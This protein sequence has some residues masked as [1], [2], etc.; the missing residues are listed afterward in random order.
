MS[1][2]MS[3]KCFWNIGYNWTKHRAMHDEEIAA[4]YVEAECARESELNMAKALKGVYFSMFMHNG[5][6]VVV[7][8]TKEK[9]A[10]VEDAL[11][12]SGLL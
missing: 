5:P 8:M 3:D 4:L 12:K 2:R 7:T 1:K 10:A 6:D 11:K 9:W